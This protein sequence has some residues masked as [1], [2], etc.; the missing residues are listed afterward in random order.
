MGTISF[1]IIITTSLISI[2]TPVVSKELPTETQI[3]ELFDSISRE[4]PKKIHIVSLY[5]KETTPPS[6]NE[7]KQ[8]MDVLKQLFEKEYYALPEPQKTEKINKILEINRSTMTGKTFNRCQ[9]WKSDQLYRLDKAW[10]HSLE[11]IDSKTNCDTTY[12]NLVDADGTASTITVNNDTKSFEKK[13]NDTKSKWTEID[14]WNA[15][16]VEPRVAIFV[17]AALASKESIKQK[18]QDISQKLAIDPVK[19]QQILAGQ[20]PAVKV[21]LDE[22]E[23]LGQTLSDFEFD[24]HIQ[25]GTATVLIECCKTNY[26]RIVR[27]EIRNKKGI[28]TLNSIRDNFDSQDFPHNYT[29]VEEGN[30]GYTTNIFIIKSVDTNPNFSDD[31]VFRFSPPKNYGVV[32]MSS[33]TPKVISFPDGVKPSRTV[34]VSIPL[35]KPGWYENPAI[36]R[37]VMLVVFLLPP[38]VM[39][40]RAVKK[41]ASK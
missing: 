22:N 2:A 14:A 23:A 41:R 1:A 35:K 9:E 33:G 34:D 3:R 4:V 20:N 30:S 15:M 28:V 11:E 39:I 7:I 27:T 36:I 19:L 38:L 37:I 25:E 5:E 21:Y 18:S 13:N 16:T 10:G 29:L 12:I 24:V 31:D 17:A 8:R 26:N 40:F 32:D 6:D